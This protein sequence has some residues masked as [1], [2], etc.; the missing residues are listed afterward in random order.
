MLS[1]SGDA[2]FS[3]QVLDALPHDLVIEVLKC[4]PTD[5][6]ETMVKAPSTFL[7]FVALARVPELA[8]SFSPVLDNSSSEAPEP[9]LSLCVSTFPHVPEADITDVSQPDSLF[10]AAIWPEEADLTDENVHEG[11]YSLHQ[12]NSTVVCPLAP[13]AMRLCNATFPLP[14]N[15]CLVVGPSCGDMRFDGVTF[16]GETLPLCGPP[17]RHRL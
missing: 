2:P 11:L 14:W 8:A 9:V 13:R 5:F 7:S 3:V 17:C 6:T 16:R 15:V 12:R 4:S 10:Q 1:I